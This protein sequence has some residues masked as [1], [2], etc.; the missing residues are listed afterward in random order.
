[1]QPVHTER[2]GPKIRRIWRELGNVGPRYTLIGG[3]AVALYCDHRESADVDLSCTGPAEHPHTIR[4]NI[5]AE[6][7][8]HKVLQRRTGVVIKFFATETS[9][10]VQVHGTDPWKTT[11]PALTAENGLRIAAPCDLAA[12]KLAAMIER[13]SPRDGEDLEALLQ[14]GADIGSAA[15]NVAGQVDRESFER[16]ADRLQH[17]PQER[18]PKLKTYGNVLTSLQRAA[19]G[20]I[21]PAPSRIIFD[22]KSP[23]RFNVTEEKIESGS[24]AVLVRVRSIREGLEWLGWNRRIDTGEIPAMERKL[25]LE[26]KRERSRAGTR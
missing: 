16:L 19:A 24:T 4:K 13:D 5:G 12:R 25:A 7:G 14:G 23:D 15:R 21:E 2:L 6:I 9:P 22:E 18:W 8:K 11:A 10:K 17:N 3:T 1:M 20:I 26:L